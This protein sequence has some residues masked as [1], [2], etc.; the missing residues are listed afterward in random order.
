MSANATALA[1]STTAKRFFAGESGMLDCGSPTR[2]LD[3]ASFM[4]SM[5]ISVE[6]FR[7][8]KMA[9]SL[10]RLASSAPEYPIV[11]SA[12]L[13]SSLSSSDRSIGLPLACTWRIFSL[14]WGVG[15]P[16][17]IVLSNLPG[18]NSASSSADARLV[19][20]ITNT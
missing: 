15:L 8:A 11:R 3:M 14:F 5:S 20:P 19:A 2:I 10:S 13:L 4:M 7:T 12:T 6:S 16:M 17:W 1:A 18:R 9:A